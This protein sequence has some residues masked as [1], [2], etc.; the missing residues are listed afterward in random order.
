MTTPTMDWPAIRAELERYNNVFP[1]AAVEAVM[2]APEQAIPHLVQEL[3]DCAAN[4]QPRLDPNDTWMLHLYALY[5]CATLR[6]EAAYPHLLNLAQLD[7][8]TL[9]EVLGD[10]VTEG[11]PR[12]LAATCPAGAEGELIALAQNQRC[13][14]WVRSGALRA[15]TLRVLEGD[16]PREAL[17]GWLVVTA[18]AEAQRMRDE[19]ITG[20]IHGEGG[21]LTWL[22]IALA[23]IGAGDQLDTVRS[24]FDDKL[25]DEEIEGW[26]GAQNDLSRDWA[27]CLEQ[28][29]DHG[30]GYPSDI[31]AEMGRW[32]CFSDEDDDEEDD[33]E[34]GPPQ[35]PFVRAE[36]KLGRNDPCSCGSGKKYK[37]CCGA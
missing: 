37:K 34:A 32:A 26:K 3:A 36:P 35:T 14:I 17:H 18:N 9:D 16:Y 5:L 21:M 8:E 24:W 11:L 27:T 4:P 19:G 25:I 2:Q 28:E 20:D 1:Q 29:L 23:E 30:W 22:E 7:T 13:D 10:H 33:E 31:V 12:A 6:V 15:L